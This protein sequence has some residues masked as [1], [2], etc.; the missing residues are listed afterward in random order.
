MTGVQW[1]GDVTNVLRPSSSCRSELRRGEVVKVRTLPSFIGA[2]RS[3]P[4][5]MRGKAW[6]LA[7]QL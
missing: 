4:K 2:V 3:L 7:C 5:R 1:D 6:R